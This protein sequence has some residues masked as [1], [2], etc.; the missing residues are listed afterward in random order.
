MVEEQSMT[1]I[2]TAFQGI[3]IMLREEIKTLEEALSAKPSSDE[4]DTIDKEKLSA[5]LQ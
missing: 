3:E 2:M 1:S 5:K 4:S